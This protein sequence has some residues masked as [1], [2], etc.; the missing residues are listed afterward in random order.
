MKMVKVDAKYT[1]LFDFARVKNIWAKVSVARVKNIDP[2]GANLHPVRMG[3]R[4]IGKSA[5][6]G[7]IRLCSLLG[8]KA[9]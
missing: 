9:L 1:S 8:F 4:T 3:R 6:I 5:G 7:G 2:S